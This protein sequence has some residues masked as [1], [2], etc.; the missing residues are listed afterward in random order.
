MTTGAPR[1]TRNPIALARQ[2][3]A[4]GIALGKLHAQQ[5]RAE[6]TAN[7]GQL[8]GGIIRLVIAVAIVVVVVIELIAFVV[9][10]LV[11]AGMWWVALLLIIG[12]LIVAGL[13]A[14]S[15]I[16]GVTSTKFTPEETIAS[17]KEDIEWAKTRLLRR[18]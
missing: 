10:L 15:G 16:R 14:W 8:K 1:P 2:L 4:G 3:V 12:M 17:V 9:S 18:D 6:M 13:L 11:S 7:L 5:A